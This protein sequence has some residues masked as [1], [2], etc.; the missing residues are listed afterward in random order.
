M[1]MCRALLCSFALSIFNQHPSNEVDITNFPYAKLPSWTNPELLRPTWDP[2]TSE[3]Q[4][5]VRATG[6]LL[7]FLN[8]VAKELESDHLDV[9]IH[10]LAYYWT[11]Y[12]PD[13]IKLH[14]NVIVDFAPLNA[15]HYHTYFVAPVL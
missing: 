7:E 15:C 8:R 4:S 14:P 6:V 2:A 10:T 9:L 1:H 12:P 13:D 11:K 3:T 5:P